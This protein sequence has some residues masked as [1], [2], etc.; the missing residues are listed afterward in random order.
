MRASKASRSRKVTPGD[1]LVDVTRVSGHTFVNTGAGADRVNVHD[2]SNLLSGIGGLLTLSGDSPQA[3][4]VNL[5]N[6]S[7]AQGTAVDAVDATQQLTVDATGGTFSLTYAPQPL[8]LTAQVGARNLSLTPGT[9]FYLVT[10][11]L[12]G[13]ESL[14]SPETF[15]TVGRNGLNGSVVLSWFPVPGATGYNVYR[16]T[17]AGQDHLLA[18]AVP[19]T[20]Y[21]DDGTLTPGA[22]SP[23]A[24]GV[25]RQ[26]T[27]TYVP[28]SGAGALQ[29]AL[30]ALVGAGNALV[31]MGGNVFRI[32][33]LGAFGGTAIPL[34][35][36]DPTQLRNGAGSNDNLYVTDLGSTAN[37]AA[38]LTSSSLTGL[39][40]SS[41][42]TIQE[43]SV[44]ATSGQ[45]N[46][47]YSFPIL[48]TGLI[49][50]WADTSPRTILFASRQ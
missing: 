14:P 48:P 12:A 50:A 30:D 29:G 2:G 13:G 11:N 38:L 23:P 18:A 17:V 21:T 24:A 27:V 33:F 34:L 9:Y 6:G 3:N 26:A 1:D 49:G 40:M 47:E 43:L 39:D 19:G 20:A 44:D 4:I 46:L 5:A 7:P 28:N 22:A 16:G 8:Q 25:T 36:T 32:H 35:V 10:A 45:Y 31:T 15:A 41:S 42:N 37:D